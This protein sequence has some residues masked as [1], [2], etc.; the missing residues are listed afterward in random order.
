[1][2]GDGITDDAAAHCQGTGAGGTSDESE[3]EETG[4]V[5]G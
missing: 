2:D 5:G 1:M 3:D 4:Q